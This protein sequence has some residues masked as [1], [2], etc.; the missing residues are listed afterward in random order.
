MCCH[1]RQ[2]PL[3]PGSPWKFLQL[4]HLSGIPRK[5]TISQLSNR[6]GRES[7]APLQDSSAVINKSVLPPATNPSSRQEKGWDTTPTRQTNPSEK[8][9]IS[10]LRLPLRTK[11]A[12]HRSV[13][14]DEQYGQYENRYIPFTPLRTYE[15]HWSRPKQTNRWRTEQQANSSCCFGS[16]PRSKEQ[17]VSASM[18]R[19]G[20]STSS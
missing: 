15:Q 13:H 20:T 4:T 8:C 5:G 16:P 2:I 17:K 9:P 14:T 3:K 6:R 10:A 1:T 11:Q 18:P 7:Q 19:N 12:W